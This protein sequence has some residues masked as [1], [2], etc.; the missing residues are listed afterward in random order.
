MDTDA[1]G[2]AHHLEELRNQL[3][4]EG[5]LML[6]VKV[7]PRAR[8][9]SVS[10]VMGNGV[11]KVKVTAAPE[12]GRANDEVCAV[13]AESLGVAKRK[14]EIVSGHTS[15]QKRVRITRLLSM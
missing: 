4:R 13:I 9:A 14:V 1:T 10:E 11:L 15:S 8:T 12:R 7:I 5:T 3:R 6:G 2:L